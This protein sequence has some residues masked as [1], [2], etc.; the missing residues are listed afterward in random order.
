MS[1]SLRCGAAATFVAVLLF[2][3]P[4]PLVAQAATLEGVVVSTITGT[5]VSGVLVAVEGGP[6]TLTDGDGTYRLEGVPPGEHRVAVVAPGCQIATATVALSALETRAV[7][8]EIA[9]D[10]EAGERAARRRRPGGKV[11]TGRD[12]EAMHASTLLDVLARVAPGMLGSTPPQPGMDP[13]ARSRSPVGLRGDVAPAVVLDGAN[14]GPSGIQVLQDIRPSDVA[15]I[16]V[17]RGAVGGWEV[18]TGGSGGLIRIQTKRGRP[19][20][21]PSLD[22][23]LCDIPGWRRGSVGRP[24]GGRA[25]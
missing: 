17:F 21:P 22:P 4:L 14:L 1:S 15:W 20:E 16:E 10:P 25:G 6:R 9:Y 19:M 2:G 3:C 5:R 23:E 13:E 7:A 11:V 18:G 8:F 12:I 24:E